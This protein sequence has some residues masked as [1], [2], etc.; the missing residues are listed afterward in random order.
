M[1]QGTAASSAVDDLRS[2]GKQSI[3]Q[4]S[5][6]FA[7]ASFFFNEAMQ[8]DA[9]MLYAWCRHCDDVI[10]GQTMGGDAPSAELSPDDRRALVAML[11]EKTLQAM[12]GHTTGQPAFDAFGVVA[13]RHNLPKD[14]PLDLIDGFAMDIIPQEG[15]TMTDLLKYCYGVAGVVGVMM[16]IIMGVDRE[17]RATLERACDMG[18]AFQMTNICR[19]ILDDARGGRIYLPTE[20]LRRHGVPAD[21]ASVLDPDNREAIWRLSLELLDLADEYYRSATEGIRRLPPRAAAAI[22]AARNIYRDIG[23]RI[24][25]GGPDIWDSRVVVSKPRKLY[26]AA[27]GS[28]TGGAA[29][30]LRRGDEM[31]SRSGLWQR[32][33]R[34]SA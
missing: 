25:Y 10:D 33:L 26:L 6:S 3:T 29:S 24:H 7:M 34:E 17:D 18:L 11:R 19:D 20:L 8:A 30:F 12:S 9:Q 23:H 15:M 2:F 21:P 27:L 31:A 16:A 22:A 14:Y 1:P 4:G 28:F 13:R 5:K 32:P